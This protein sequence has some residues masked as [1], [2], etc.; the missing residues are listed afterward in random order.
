MQADTINNI[1]GLLSKLSNDKL[2]EV[3]DFVSFLIEKERRHRIFE[4]RVVKA[5]K[6]PLETF[7]SVDDFM[8]AVDEERYY[9]D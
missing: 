5:S 7:E 4:D 1:E 9:C 3:E 8:K 6:E 2:K